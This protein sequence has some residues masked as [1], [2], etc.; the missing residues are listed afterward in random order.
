MNKIPC[1]TTLT[2]ENQEF[3][4]REKIVLTEVLNAALDKERKQKKGIIEDVDLDTAFSLAQSYRN[5]GK[6]SIRMGEHFQEIYDS[7]LSIEE[8]K[9]EKELEVKK[10]Q[11]LIRKQQVKAFNEYKKEYGKE[12]ERFRDE[13]YEVIVKFVRETCKEEFRSFFYKVAKV[14]CLKNSDGF[15]VDE[16]GDLLF[17]YGLPNS[18]KE[19]IKEVGGL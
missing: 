12:L 17:S 16:G 13:P 7:L 1:T 10:R 6:L 2:P 9:R 3:V 19:D 18:W 4:K 11:E 5:I 8:M 15:P 14:L